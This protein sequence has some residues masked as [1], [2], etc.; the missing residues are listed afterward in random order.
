MAALAV[1]S[2]EG[3]VDG[4]GFFWAAVLAPRAAA[5]WNARR[6][7]SPRRPTCDVSGSAGKI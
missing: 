2:W 4:L 1:V 3:A 7:R 6:A 5:R